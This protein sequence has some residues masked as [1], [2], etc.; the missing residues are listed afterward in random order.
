VGQY[1]YFGGDR[2]SKSGCKGLAPVQILNFPM[3]VDSPKEPAQVLLLKC[4]DPVQENKYD[5][6]QAI[7]VAFFVDNSLVSVTGGS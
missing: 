4:I 7:L 3:Q 5:H 6:I 2:R 1:Q